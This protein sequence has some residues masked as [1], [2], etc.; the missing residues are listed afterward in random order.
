MSDLPKARQE[1]L[2][3]EP[4]KLGV[5]EREAARRPYTTPVL[6]ELGS[7]EQVTEGVAGPGADNG[8]ASF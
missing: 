6:T 1:G 7:V 8:S 5:S 4:A 3:F 2:F